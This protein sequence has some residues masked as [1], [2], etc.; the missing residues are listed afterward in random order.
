[1][2]EYVV[3]KIF[4]KEG[5]FMTIVERFMEYVKI[6]TQSDENIVSCPSTPNQKVLGKLLVE[7]MKEVGLVDAHMDEHGYIYGWLPATSGLEDKEV[8]GLISHMDTAPSCSGKNVNPHI[9]R[10][11]DGRD[12]IL[13]EEKN[14][15]MKRELFPNLEEYINQDLIVT[16]GTTLLGADDKAGI[17]EI[18]GAIEKL[19][20]TRKK[21]GKIAVAFTPDEEIGRGADL[22]DIKKFGADYAYTVDG[23]KLGEL[24]YENFNAASALVTINGVNIHPGEAKNKMKNANLI[25][26]EFNRLLPECEVPAHTEEY[27][28]F[29]HLCS[30]CGSEEKATL[31]Y[32]VRDHD[33]VKFEK[34][35]EFMV[36]AA[37]FINEK[38]GEDTVVLEIKDSYY[39]M[40]EMI[41]KRMDIV[42]K[43]KEAFVKCGIEPIVVPI[44]G[45][46]DGARLSFEGL[47]CPNLSTGGI[48]FHGRNEF[49]PVNAM[50]KMVEVI[51]CLL[52]C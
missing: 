8:I 51:T 35:K 43:A 5:R 19:Q 30:M 49:I 22:F 15:V 39:N 52:E 16:D 11:Y 37:S 34:R 10:N 45:G 36:K 17:V 28:G 24:E 4:M 44:R 48:N 25:A 6:D 32:I 9:V 42:E 50:E 26:M 33:K 29:Y 40:K 38:Y 27:E 47:L 7:H 13:N 14:I 41:E 46:T 21:H 23:G 1:M 12:I 31:D 20:S 18:L 3:V 2:I